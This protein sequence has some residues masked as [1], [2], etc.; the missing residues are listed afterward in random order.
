MKKRIFSLLLVLCVGVTALLMSGCQKNLNFE[1]YSKYSEQALIN[2]Y[3]C[4]LTEKEDLS[5]HGDFTYTEKSELKSYE[6]EVL[7]SQSTTK[8]TYQRKGQGL[9][10]VLVVTT[11]NETKTY[12]EGTQQYDVSTTKTVDIYTKIVTEGVTTYH[13]LREYTNAEG[14]VDKYIYTTYLTEE[15]YISAVYNVSED[16]MDEISEAHPDGEIVLYST[17]GEMKAKDTLAHTSRILLGI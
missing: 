4:L 1:E 12:N 11:E 3:N 6:G 13:R 7:Q 17:I 5:S 16:V 9:D 15:L 2:T 14:E 8:D 10:T